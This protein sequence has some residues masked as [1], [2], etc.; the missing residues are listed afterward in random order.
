VEDSVRV[1]YQEVAALLAS[2]EQTSR[3][4]LGSSDL[5]LVAEA[6]AAEV[7]VERHSQNLPLREVAT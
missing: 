7:V 1:A 3:R 5:I 4:S 6:A 2:V